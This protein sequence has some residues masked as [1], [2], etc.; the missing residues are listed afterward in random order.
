HRNDVLR[1]VVLYFLLVGLSVLTVAP[2]VWMFFTSLHPPL[3]PVPTPATLFRPEH[4]EFGN[5]WR[6]LSFPELPVPR[7]ALNSIIV[8]AGVAVS[9]LILSS[10]AAYGFARLEFRGRDFLFGAFMLTMMIPG[11]V[12]VVPLFLTA[13]KLKMLNTYAGLILPFPYMSTAFGTFLLRNF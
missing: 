8:T 11:M 6:V 9:Q 5:Y 7:F 13:H 12:M 1:K 3:S 2:F 4:W 10:L